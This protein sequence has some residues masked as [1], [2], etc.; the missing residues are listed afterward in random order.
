[1]DI[2]EEHSYLVDCPLTRVYVVFPHDWIQIRHFGQEAPG[3]GAE[4]SC[5]R[6]MET[7]LLLSPTIA[8]RNFDHFVE[9]VSAR[10]F[11]V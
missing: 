5:V 9:V 11:I 4:S 7:T 3:S 1:M 10:F 6:D 8:D 2:F